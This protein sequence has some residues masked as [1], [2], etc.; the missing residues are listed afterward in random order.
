MVNKFEIWISQN[1]SLLN[2]D[3]IGLFKDSLKCFKNDI[4]R[5]SYLLAYQGMMLQIR[6][7]IKRS[8][9]PTDFPEQDWRDMQRGLKDQ[10]SW[11][12]TNYTAIVRQEKKTAHGIIPPVLDMPIAVRNE[13]EHWRYLRNVCAHY[14]DYMFAKA[15]TLTL[16]A[17][18]MQ[19]LL[20]I[21][22]EGGMSSLLNEFERH[23]D[24]LITS[25]NEPIDPLLDKITVMVRPEQMTL[26]ITELSKTYDRYVPLGNLS[27]ILKKLYDKSECSIKEAIKAFIHKNAT[28]Q[29]DFIDAYPETIVDIIPQN[30]IYSFAKSS[31]LEL[32]TPI[33]VWS[34]MLMAGMIE[35]YDIDELQNNILYFMYEHNKGVYDLSE[36][37]I[38]I[39]QKKR[40]F[41]SFVTRFL[42]ANN[43]IHFET[44]QKINYSMNFYSSNFYIIPID[45]LFVKA[46]VDVF[47]NVKYPMALC[48]FIKGEYFNDKETKS[49]F[50]DIVN[51]KGLSLPN[52]LK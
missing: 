1:E 21:S 19:Y 36:I 50:M 26:F 11:D 9:K 38:L 27:S 15:H 49:K 41:T 10:N 30:E 39:L 35:K 12:N 34:N 33:K 13:F 51:E 24:S 22:V 28:I 44:Y 14:K 48:N 43:T 20:N 8:N 2:S 29:R 6:E 5:P 31:I 7:T 40:Y 16:Y 23:F 3:A 25:P 45:E 42:D 46:V 32:N 4:D 52:S 47:N 17:F 37:Q 18:I